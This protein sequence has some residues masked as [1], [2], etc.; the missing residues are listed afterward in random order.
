MEKF[1]NSLK[2]IIFIREKLNENI[3]TN[4]EEK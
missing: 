1:L 4:E 2:Y 3:F